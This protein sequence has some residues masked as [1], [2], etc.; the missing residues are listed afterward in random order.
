[1]TE[2]LYI[3]LGSQAQDIIHWLIWSAQNHEIIA[4]G[5]LKGACE[6]DQL[7]IKAQTRQVVSF[8]PSC[9]IALKQLKIPGKS[10]R[11]IRLAAPYMLEDDLAQDVEQL[12][13]AFAN[14]KEDS[15][16]HNCFV[17]VVERIQLEHWQTWLK[18]VAI[19]C[20][21][22]IPD[23]LALPEPETNWTSVTLAEQILIRQ[24]VW[25]GLVV[26][27]AIWPILEPRLVTEIS[28]NE[29]ND[30]DQDQAAQ[31]TINSYSNLTAE[32]IAVQSMPEELPLALLAEH[33]DQQSFNLLQ[34]EYQVKQAHST[35][36][37]N[38]FSTAILAGVALL[39]SLGIKG[40]QLSQITAQQ[41]SVQQE[42]VHLYKKTFPKSKRV[43]VSTVRSQLKRK[44]AEFGAN[45]TQGGFLP[46]LMKV[47]PAFAAVPQLKPESLKFDSKRQEF[48]IQATA[49]D[50]QYFEKFKTELKKA[51]LTVNQG[52]LNNQGEQISGSFSIKG[53]I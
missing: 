9:D 14:L 51:K 23:I 30:E 39:L 50:Y 37:I 1:M 38:W 5:E 8:V 7:T 49:S 21:V 27:S 18:N 45:T 13:F 16:G 31:I 52:A 28:K 46:M 3:R 25:Q 53:R 4:S 33:A 11:A 22:M 34:G 17:A 48:R 24:S 42:I 36:L 10:Q 47:R 35:L 41:H 26:D 6:L 2:T 32:H 40:I 12:F 43:K 19:S 20:K 15:Q 44:L 29:K